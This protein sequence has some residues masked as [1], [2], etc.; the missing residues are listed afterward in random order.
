MP[1]TVIH[2]FHDDDA[3][4]GSGSHVAERIRQVAGEQ[5]LELE[6]YC[7]GPAQKALSDTESAVRA[8]YNAQ[9]D[10]LVQAGVPV[11]ACLNSATAVGTVDALTERGVKLQFAR[12]AFA[13]YG[14]EGAAVI[15]F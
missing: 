9:I 8:E 1:K 14:L 11:G 13:R 15:T 7:F 10:A 12:D 2:L 3:S 5:G 6:V 4:L